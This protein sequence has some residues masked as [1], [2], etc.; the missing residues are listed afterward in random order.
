MDKGLFIGQIDDTI[1]ES[2]CQGKVAMVGWSSMDVAILGINALKI[3]SRNA[4]FVVDPVKTISKVGADAILLLNNNTDTDTSRVLDQRIIICGLGEYEVGTVKISGITV[5]P[6]D[7]QAG[8]GVV[9]SLLLDSI[10][11]VLGKVSDISRLYDNTPSCQIAILK[12]DDDLKSIAAKLEPKIIVL[13][14]DKK[15]EGAKTL[16]KQGIQPVQK[17]TITRDKLPDEMQV[18]VL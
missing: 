3:R 10:Q 18:V 17:F 9:Y 15:I 11:V 8:N 6:P 12:V 2:S 7:R 14:G 5:S 13:Y 4:S 1:K 16:G